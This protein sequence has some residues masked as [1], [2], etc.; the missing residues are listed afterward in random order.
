MLYKLLL[1]CLLWGLQIFTAQ[2]QVDLVLSIQN[3]KYAKGAI[4]V[5]FYAPE[6]EFLGKTTW[7]IRRAYQV[8]GKEQEFVIQDIPK[9]EYSIAILH[10]LNDNADMDFNWIGIP[11][12]GYGF[13]NNP[14]KLFRKPTYEETKIDLQEDLA[15]TVRLINW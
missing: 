7:S 5:G 4:V 1:I 8:E 3:L 11:K 15:L 12:E 14:R 2:A 10:D 13:S 9:G 6:D